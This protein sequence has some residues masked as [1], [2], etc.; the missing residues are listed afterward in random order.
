MS[1][2]VTFGLAQI[3]LLLL[4]ALALALLVAAVL[5]AR[6]RRGPKAI[7]ARGLPGLALLLVA[8]LLLWIATLL[9]TYLGL[10]GEI[11]AAHVIA[12]PVAGQDTQLDIELTLFGEDGA[13]ETTSTHRVEGNLWV[14]QANIV[15]LHPWVNALGFHS[16]YKIT[17]LYGQRLDGKSPTQDHLFLNGGDR[18]FFEDM[19]SGTWYTSPFVK[20]AYGNAVIATPGE[21]DVLISRD[22][23][24]V[25]QSS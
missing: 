21:F 18:D 22:A 5:A 16:G 25:R 8:V 24:K 15:E 23:I 14:L 19:N 6:R 3:G 11:K 7:A 13:P 1:F 20:S 2:P 12:K 9:Q 4:I 10:T 17:R